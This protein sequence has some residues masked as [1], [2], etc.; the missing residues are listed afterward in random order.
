MSAIGSDK[1]PGVVQSKDG[2]SVNTRATALVASIK[3]DALISR[4]SSQRNGIACH[5]SDNYS[6]GQN[7][8]VRHIAFEDGINWVARLRLPKL[9]G[10]VGESEPLDVQSSMENMIATTNYLRATTWI[11]V[12]E[13]F[14]YDLDPD[15]E[16]GAPFILMAY[17]HG[18]TAKELS[19]IRGCQSNVFGTP[20]EDERF[21]EQMASIQ[22]ELFACKFDRI[23]SLYESEADFTIGPELETGQGPWDTAE[24]YYSAFARYLLET[25]QERGSSEFQQSRS[26]QVPQVFMEL[27]KFY[28]KGNPIG[29]FGLTNRDLGAH[30]VLV[31][32]SF[33]II[34]MIDLDRVEAVPIEKAAQFPHY[35]GLDRP[36]PGHVRTK[37]EDV[38]RERIAGPLCERYT[39]LVRAAVAGRETAT[40]VKQTPN[41]GDYLMSDG[42]SVVQGLAHYV[43]HDKEL[44]GYWMEAYEMLVHKAQYEKESRT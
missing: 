39:Q 10:T 4:A 21:W 22:A 20:S 25:A 24:Q 6:L 16:V 44:S 30:N 9:K 34:G 26:F 18:T 33:K 35:M 12:A 38:E 31:D 2:G 29:P 42:A 32:R 28:G 43:I 37:P 14:D 3:W 15:N 19:S 41:L 7:N 8:L 23:G 11:Q 27:I 5:L 13:I 17:I 36:L 40:S 1:W